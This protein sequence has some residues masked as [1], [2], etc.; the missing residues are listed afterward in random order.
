MQQT[1]FGIVCIQIVPEHVR[2]FVRLIQ[3]V[4]K[5]V[6]FYSPPQAKKSLFALQKHDFRLK[7]S[8][9]LIS[10]SNLFPPAAGVF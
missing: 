2:V 1:E 8:M 4:E 5:L 7:T 6:T 3:A 9:L 10:K